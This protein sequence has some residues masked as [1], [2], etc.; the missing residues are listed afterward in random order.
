MKR[1]MDAFLALAGL[2]LIWPLLAAIGLAILV[3]SGG[4]VLFSQIR[5]GKNGRFFNLRKFRTMEV[6]QGTEAGIFEPGNKNRV[7]TFGRK[8]RAS[9]LDELPQLWNVLIGDMSMVGPRPEV[10]GWVAAFPDRWKRIHSIKPG[11]TDPA[12]IVFYDEE[13][14]LA[15]SA[16]P[17]WTY[18]ETILPQKLSLY[19]NYLRTR[20]LAGDLRI[21]IET[22]ARVIIDVPGRKC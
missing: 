6:R 3:T 4:P 22:F 1:G 11:I 16:N 10:P 15:R 8:L 14:I 7:T 20:T 2:T 9:K 5:V 12:S 17:E 13:S 21:F 19:E 18:R